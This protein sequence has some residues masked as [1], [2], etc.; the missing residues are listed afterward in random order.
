MDIAK[1]GGIGMQ[2]TQITLYE[3]LGLNR[4]FAVEYTS[5]PKERFVSVRARKATFQH[6]S[7][8]L[9]RSL[10]GRPN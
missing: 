3:T 1:S 7:S 10:N 5:F 8:M 4:R 2:S 6:K 9:S